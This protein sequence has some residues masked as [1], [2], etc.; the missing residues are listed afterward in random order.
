MHT[1][2]LTNHSNVRYLVCSS[3]VHVQKSRTS[4]SFNCMI[5]HGPDHRFT[6]PPEVMF[7]GWMLCSNGIQKADYSNSTLSST[8]IVGLNLISKPFDLNHHF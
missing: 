6:S 7:L 3:V 2:I 1:V 8:Y 5:H 4:C